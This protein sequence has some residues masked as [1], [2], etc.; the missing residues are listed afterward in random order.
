M[1]ELVNRL[2]YLMTDVL[3]KNISGQ[4]TDCT[5]DGLEDCTVVLGWETVE[6]D[7]SKVPH[8]KYPVIVIDLADGET[9]ASID[10]GEDNGTH[11]RK[12]KLQ[13]D[14]V[15]LAKS[16]RNAIIGDDGILYL[17]DIFKSHLCSSDFRQMDDGT[18]MYTDAIEYP[19]DTQDGTVTDELGHI[20]ARA[21]RVVLTW[22]RLELA[23]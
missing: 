5:L 10:S 15:V 3:P 9:V 7:A 1:R 20:W 21:R 19:I 8:G 14:L 17:W 2:H 16:K 23:R 13:I 6:N 4:F 22:R 12:M 18:G 11:E